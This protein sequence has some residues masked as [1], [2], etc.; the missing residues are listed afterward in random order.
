MLFRYIAELLKPQGKKYL[1]PDEK[2]A[3]QIT[4]CINKNRLPI[5]IFDKESPIFQILLNFMSF[6]KFI[7]KEKELLSI[8]FEE[9]K[10]INNILLSKGI[11]PILIKGI[12][13]F[14]YKSHNIDILVNEAEIKIVKEILEENEYFHLNNIVE[15]GKILL[16]KLKDSKEVCSIHIHNIVGWDGLKF[17]DE[18]KVIERAHSYNLDGERF[19]FP[20][21]E[22][23]LLITIAHAL[24][25]NKEIALNDFFSYLSSFKV[26][27][28]LDW[29]YI[30]GVGIEKGWL[31]GLQF[32]L[33]ML[34]EMEN[35]MY[36]HISI[37]KA[38]LERS[39]RK[40][41]NKYVGYYQK[42][43]V[44]GRCKFPL[45]LSKVMWK[46]FFL[47]KGLSGKKKRE[48]LNTFNAGLLSL[49]RLMGINPQKRL[50]IVF[51]GMDG[52]GKTTYAHSI[53]QILYDCGLK[54]RYYWSRIEDSPFIKCI[55]AI[56]K[57]YIRSHHIDIKNTN[58]NQYVSAKLFNKRRWLGKPLI[59][60]IWL[61]INFIDLFWRYL[62]NIWI[63][64]VI[65]DK[66]VICD[67]YIGDALADV[68]MV[69][70]IKARRFK[71]LSFRFFPRQ[72]LILFLKG[73]VE[74]IYERMD[75][76]T[77]LYK[78]ETYL[79]LSAFYEEIYNRELNTVQIKTTNIEKKEVVNKL[80]SIIFRRIFTK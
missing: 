63:P 50:L 36:Q 32:G 51:T 65:S 25:E 49:K 35:F 77:S 10:F 52:A 73:D 3:K 62:L 43:I 42:M 29:D 68:Y 8:I 1:I 37:P 78:K 57:L 56:A 18:K 15:P 46:I 16:K 6:N 12:D 72:Y 31:F 4:G 21:P 2:T 54:V 44:K 11:Y 64:L 7:R 14:P 23:F 60:N 53:E 34:S 58:S 59:K 39:Q 13:F 33:L 69:S 47:K 41:L 75:K 19:F 76:K 22:D 9:Y 67:R 30:F 55:Y 40:L 66:I 45:S 71:K 70:E 20:S 48:I 80:L 38:I 26:S 28:S 24:Y 79:N 74:E 5:L 61:I 17:L 27:V